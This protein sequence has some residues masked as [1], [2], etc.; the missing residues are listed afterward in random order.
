MIHDHLSL[1][2]E[3]CEVLESKAFAKYY[4]KWSKEPRTTFFDFKINKKYTKIIQTNHGSNSV[5]AFI[6]N[7]NLDML[8]AA[9]W[10][11]PAKDARYN[12]LRDF[13]DLLEVCDPHGGYLY[14]NKTLVG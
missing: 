13:N 1:V 8:K 2:Q 10:N 5:H 7:D 4:G 11:S 6:N 9:T 3:L 14:K 12:L